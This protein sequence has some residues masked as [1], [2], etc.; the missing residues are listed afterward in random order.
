MRG[1]PAERRQQGR[2]GG[3]GE[4]G[5]GRRGTAVVAE[6]LRVVA[7]DEGGVAADG[8][9][10]TAQ[11]LGAHA[12]AIDVGWELLGGRGAVVRV[13]DVGAPHAVVAVQHVGTC[14]VEEGGTVTIR[15]PQLEYVTHLCYVV[16]GLISACKYY[17]THITKNTPCTKLGDTAVGVQ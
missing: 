11:G 4:N 17:Y 9:G 2:E 12:G 5:A 15:S 7:V 13:G 10:V 1:L 16:F 8:G 6:G 14:Q 3:R